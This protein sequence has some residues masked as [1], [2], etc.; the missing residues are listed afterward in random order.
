[1]KQKE[2]LYC[3]SL[4]SMET[5][6]IRKIYE[7]EPKGSGYSFR[8]AYIPMKFVQEKDLE[9]PLCHAGQ[10]YFFG[11]SLKDLYRSSEPTKKE[12]D[13]ALRAQFQWLKLTEQKLKAWDSLAS[14]IQEGDTNDSSPKDSLKTSESTIENPTVAVPTFR[15]VSAI[16]QARQNGAFV[17]YCAVLLDES[18]GKEAARVSNAGKA[19][20]LKR[21]LLR[22]IKEILEKIPKG[23]AKVNICAPDPFVVDMFQKGYLRAYASR[24][25]KTKSGENLP[26]LDLWEPIWAAAAARE[27]TAGLCSKEDPEWNACFKAA[28]QNAETIYQRAENIKNQK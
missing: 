10:Y 24:G 6:C 14:L 11:F 9:K 19:S 1:M 28:A 3:L 21:V 18:T 8:A 26:D 23:K 25:W 20:D 27:I 12:L 7:Y 15:I 2:P 4:G 13:T 16:A 5:A 17:G 22:S